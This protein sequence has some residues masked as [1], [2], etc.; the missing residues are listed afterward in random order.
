MKPSRHRALMK[1][2]AILLLN[3]SCCVLLWDPPHMGRHLFYCGTWIHPCWLLHTG[4]NRTDPRCSDAPLHAVQSGTRTKQFQDHTRD[5]E[6]S[7]PPYSR[8]AG[9]G[10]CGDRLAAR[11]LLCDL[12]TIPTGSPQRC[13][14][15][16]RHALRGFCRNT[17]NQLRS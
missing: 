8:F 5:P 6:G 16:H 15:S 12:G 7:A 14:T 13:R 3:C 17:R 9:R 4:P 1:Y 2:P 10:F 11:N